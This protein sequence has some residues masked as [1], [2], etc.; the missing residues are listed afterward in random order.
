VDQHQNS[1]KITV[2]IQP[3]MII[4]EAPVP[5]AEEPAPA[6]KPKPAGYN[7]VEAAENLGMSRRKLRALIT[8]RRVRC[9]QIDSRNFLFSQADLNGFSGH[10][11]D[12]ATTHLTLKFNVKPCI[13]VHLRVSSCLSQN[14]SYRDRREKVMR[15]AGFEPPPLP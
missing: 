11:Q 13:S 8:R 4:R 10:I 9:T 7:L 5:S 1:E 6:A 2:N 12:Q 15:D 3:W 14:Q